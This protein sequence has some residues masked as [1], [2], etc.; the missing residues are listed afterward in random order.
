[1]THAYTGGPMRGH[2]RFNFDKFFEVEQHC[3]SIGW[4]V[5]NPARHDLETYPLMETWEGFAD[6][7]IEKCPEF[8]IKRAMRW[9]LQEVIL[10]DVLL[11]M[12]GWHHSSGALLE[13][14]VADVCGVPVKVWGSDAL[15]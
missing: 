2:P 4:T 9:D 7:D 15:Y 6:G 14:H 3:L 11:L 12:P 8:D 10:A 13:K 5:S 1:M